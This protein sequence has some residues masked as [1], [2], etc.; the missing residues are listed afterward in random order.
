MTQENM[1]EISEAVAERASRDERTKLLAK[2][3]GLSVQSLV[4]EFTKVYAKIGDMNDSKQYSKEFFAW[5]D[6][7]LSK[8]EDDIDFHELSESFDE[9]DFDE[10]V[11]TDHEC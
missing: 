6:F 11:D 3:S 7:N 5:V 4:L 2:E 9:A 8:G 1:V 10:S